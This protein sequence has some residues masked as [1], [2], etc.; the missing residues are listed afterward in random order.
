M[1]YIWK[2]SEETKSSVCNDAS[3]KSEIY[4][5]LV[6]LSWTGATTKEKLATSSCTQD[7]TDAVVN[8]IFKI[9]HL[10]QIILLYYDVCTCPK[11]FFPPSQ[12]AKIKMGKENDAVMT[13]LY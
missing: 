11:V 3:H 2:E 8:P 7:L 5:V 6:R 9:K 13:F 12:G 10:E 4:Q 1:L